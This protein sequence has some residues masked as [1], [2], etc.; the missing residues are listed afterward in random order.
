MGNSS[1][2][3][4]SLTTYGLQRRTMYAVELVLACWTNFQAMFPTLLGYISVILFLS[5]SASPSY[6]ELSAFSGSIATFIGALLAVPG[7]LSQTGQLLGH[8]L[9]LA[10]L[11]SALS[12]D[13]HSEKGHP[14]DEPCCSVPADPESPRRVLEVSNLS[15]QAVN[16]KACKA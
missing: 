2:P 4:F 7:I 1:A 10:E 13:S 5:S 16:G 15:C 14:Q 6:G 3:R 12:F 8:G 9:R 11:R